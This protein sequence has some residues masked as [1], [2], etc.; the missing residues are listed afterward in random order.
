MVKLQCHCGP[1]NGLAVV[2]IDSL[3]ESELERRLC[4]RLLRF[5]D[6]DLDFVV[7]AR[8]SERLELTVAGRKWQVTLQR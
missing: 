7:T 8:E 6:E 4:R 2:P 3:P 1:W 5:N